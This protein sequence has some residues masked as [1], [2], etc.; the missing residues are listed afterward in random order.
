LS[1]VVSVEN[2]GYTGRDQTQVGAKRGTVGHPIPGVAVRIVNPESFAALGP[3]EEGMLLVKGP[4]VMVGYLGEPDRTRQVIW[5]DGWY[6]TGDVAQLD[7]DGFIKITDRLSRFSKIAGEMVSHVQVEDALHRALGCI[8]PRMVVTSVSDDQKGERFV[9]LHTDL[10]LEVEELLKRM[11]DSGLPKL[12]V[13]RRENFFAVQDLPM[14]GSGKLD[15]KQVK[16]IAKRFSSE[17][18]AGD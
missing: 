12:W 6:I 15:L 2:S 16:E 5:D 18:A 11:R 14:L 10:G 9:V 8:E 17:V 13:P 1:P 4:S 7:E 3:G